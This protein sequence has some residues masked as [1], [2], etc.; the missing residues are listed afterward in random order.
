MLPQERTRSRLE[1]FGPSYAEEPAPIGTARTAEDQER[2]DALSPPLLQ[3]FAKH[4]RVR[5]CKRMLQPK[6]LSR[7]A[8]PRTQRAI[9]EQFLGT[10]P[11]AAPL[12]RAISY[13]CMHVR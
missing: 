12:R 5:R 6:R 13:R 8:R 4:D 11:M 7:T 2:V 10:A 9:P 1:P 3:P